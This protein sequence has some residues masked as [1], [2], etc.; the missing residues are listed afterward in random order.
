MITEAMSHVPNVWHWQTKN[1]DGVIPMYVLSTWIAVFAFLWT[2]MS[3]FNVKNAR[4]AHIRES[5][6]Y[7]AAKQSIRK[8]V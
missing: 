1:Y 2:I 3:P 4:N 7:F 6:C 8:I 5:A